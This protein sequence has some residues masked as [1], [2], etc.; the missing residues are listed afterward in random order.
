[1]LALNIEA[2]YSNQ[3][4][5]VGEDDYAVPVIRES[6]FYLHINFFENKFY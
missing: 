6:D 4:L 3:V 2:Q 1:M 5:N